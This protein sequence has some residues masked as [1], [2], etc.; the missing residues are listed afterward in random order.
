[1]GA[2][3]GQSIS[4]KSSIGNSVR[5]S[6][7]RPSWQLQGGQLRQPCNH[8]RTISLV[9]LLSAAPHINAILSTTLKLP[10]HSPFA[11]PQANIKWSKITINSV[12]TGTS[13]TRA[14][15]TPEE[16]HVALAAII[17]YPPNYTKT[18]MGA[19]TSGKP[20]IYFLYFFMLFF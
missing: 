15:Y 8:S 18:L 5:S 10:S 6:P 3:H 19:T 14:P 11:Q 2:G 17:R 1:M 13:P 12:P 20:L 7:H 9:L 16:C 4:V